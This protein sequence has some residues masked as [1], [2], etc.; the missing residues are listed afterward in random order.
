ML[1]DFTIHPVDP[2]EEGWAP[3]VLFKPIR[4]R[5][6]LKDSMNW[7]AR[8]TART[9]FAKQ[10]TGDEGYDWLITEDFEIYCSTITFLMM[11]RL[12]ENE[13]FETLIERIEER[14][15]RDE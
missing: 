1:A 14:N 6:F 9:N 3:V 2:R 12:S 5:I 10:M 11:A 4:Y 7:M 13:E 8:L 15:D